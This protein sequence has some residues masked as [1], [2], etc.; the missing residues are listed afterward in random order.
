MFHRNTE[1]GFKTSYM[2]SSLVKCAIGD[3]AKCAALLL[4]TL[5]QF[6]TVWLVQQEE[7]FKLL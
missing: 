3:N 1:G 6:S 4:S 7:I 2:Q 5:Q